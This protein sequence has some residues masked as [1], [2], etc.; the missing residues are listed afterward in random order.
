MLAK[1]KS[2]VNEENSTHSIYGIVLGIIAVVALGGI[3]Y[4]VS[5][6]EDTVNQSV[7]INNTEPTIDAV[8]MKSGVDCATGITLNTT[9]STF[10]LSEAGSTHTVHACGTATDLNGEDQIDS[11]SQYD[12]ELFDDV[13]WDYGCTANDNNCYIRTYISDPADITISNCSGTTCD[14]DIKVDTIKFFANS[15]Q[16]KGGV[17]VVDDDASAVVQ[18]SSAFTIN[19]LTAFSVTSAA[20]FG[21]VALG[22]DSEQQTIIFTNYG[23]VIVDA[24]QT[25]NGN[26]TCTVGSI[27]VG[28]VEWSFTNGFEYGAGTDMTTTATSITTMSLAKSTVTGTPETKP[29]Y[30]KLHI[31]TTGVGGSCMNTVTFTAVANG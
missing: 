15:S 13:V 12:L 3:G 8:T 31:P 25:A 17:R 21:T 10:N 23:N 6:A 14:F 24:E 30:L 11:A 16:W 28:N 18:T 29:M 20:N 22:G 19:S 1:N 2:M 5:R 26:M 27:P 9:D 7:V 4:I